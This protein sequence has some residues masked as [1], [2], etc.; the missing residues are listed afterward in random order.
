MIHIFWSLQQLRTYL[1]AVLHSTIHKSP[2]GLEICPKCRKDFVNLMDWRK[3]SG[4]EWWM[5]LRC[6][7]CGFTREVTV[8]NNDAESF[9]DALHFLASPLRRKLRQMENDRM[10]EWVETMATALDQDLFGPGDFA[11]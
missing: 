10:A 2:Q 11:R 8:S 1:N 6:G 7:E 3:A 4:E 9:E 5:F